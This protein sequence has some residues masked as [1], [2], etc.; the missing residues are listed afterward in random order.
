MQQFGI[1]LAGSI[2]RRILIV[3][4][5]T[6]L[7]VTV[8]VKIVF[9]LEL[10]G[11][12]ETVICRPEIPDFPD[13]Q[14][15]QPDDTPAEQHSDEPE[16]DKADGVTLFVGHPVQVVFDAWGETYDTGGYMGGF[17]VSFPQRKAAVIL[18]KSGSAWDAPLTGEEPVLY[19]LH[20]GNYQLEEN[21]SSLMTYA[22]LTDAAEASGGTIELSDRMEG[23]ES[24]GIAQI[25]SVECGGLEYSYTWETGKNCQTPAAR[26]SL[27]IRTPQSTPETAIRR[28]IR[29]PCMRCR[30]NTV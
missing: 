7:G 4:L 13:E 18:D 19:E 15:E 2:W 22:E 3:L 9:E 27:D 12:E 21:Y 5:V 8:V 28:H 23:Y 17:M 20:W 10:V 11:H 26:S 29:R 6:L 14:P 16:A 25:A 24:E 30:R 1:W